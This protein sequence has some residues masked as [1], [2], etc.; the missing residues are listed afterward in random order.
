MNN[1]LLMTQVSN[2]IITC[3]GSQG[4][5]EQGWRGSVLKCQEA[6]GWRRVSFFLPFLKLLFDY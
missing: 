2:S 5:H 4:L 6:K 3:L 1:E